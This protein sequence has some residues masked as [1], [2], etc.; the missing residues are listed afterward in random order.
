M[1]H[2]TQVTLGHQRE[3]RTSPEC[4]KSRAEGT[5]WVVRKSDSQMVLVP[6]PLRFTTD[7]SILSNNVDQHP[8]LQHPLLLFLQPSW[9]YKLISLHLCLIFLL[10]PFIPPLHPHGAG[11]SGQE[12][13]IVSFA[14]SFRV[15][16]GWMQGDP[17][18]SPPSCSALNIFCY[19][20][21][22]SHLPCI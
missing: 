18:E 21:I 10:W 22:I 8:S 15:F 20:C 3:N 16:P 2:C 9:M 13:Y 5:V 7:I 19:R 4:C 6:G 1:N 17:Q 11:V 12:L 14:E